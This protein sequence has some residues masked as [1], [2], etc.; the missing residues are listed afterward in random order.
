MRK[1]RLLIEGT[2]DQLQADGQA[3]AR[4]SAG[5]G[6]GGE[7]REIGRP[8]VSD[9]QRD[10]C[11][12]LRR[13]CARIPRRSAGRGR[14]PWAQ[15]WRHTLE[16]RVK[17]CEQALSHIES[18]Q[19][20]MRR[21]PSRLPR[22]AGALLRRSRR[23]APG[24]IRPLRERGGLRRAKCRSPLPRFFQ[25]RKGNFLYDGAAL[26][27]HAHG[28]FGGA[29]HFGV[30]LFPIK[31][32]RTSQSKFAE[33]LSQRAAIILHR[34]WRRSRVQRDR[35][36]RSRQGGSPR[37]PRC[38]PWGRRDRTRARAAWCRRR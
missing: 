35:A 37:P 17:F 18:R 4:K 23:R 24:N 14:E 2:A 28:S 15:R 1:K 3:V 25:V 11:R 29:A 36:R 8:G 9:D 10:A 7:S 19:I 31:F 5:D 32:A 6:N 27:H 16:G 20:P 33:R 21:A 22:C 12:F 30:Q 26:L 34:F 38:A 13:Q